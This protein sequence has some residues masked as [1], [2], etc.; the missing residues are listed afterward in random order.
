M[1]NISI[2]FDFMQKKLT[3]EIGKRFILVCDKELVY[4]E[5]ENICVCFRPPIGYLEKTFVCSKH[6]ELKNIFHD[7]DSLLIN[8][9]K[10][11]RQI[12]SSNVEEIIE[13]ICLIISSRLSVIN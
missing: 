4:L 9:P 3:E 7:D 13:Q 11:Q 10:I 1:T 12:T 8:F 2:I 6:I 5:W